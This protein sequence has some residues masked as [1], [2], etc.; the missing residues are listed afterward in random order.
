MGSKTRKSDTQAVQQ[1]KR[2]EIK[3]VINSLVGLAQSVDYHILDPEGLPP[4]TG[5][6]EFEKPVP[7]PKTVQF[8][9]YNRNLWI[10]VNTNKVLLKRIEFI[11]DQYYKVFVAFDVKSMDGSK[12][13]M[14]HKYSSIVEGIALLYHDNPRMELLSG[15]V[16]IEGDNLKEFLRFVDTA[17]NEVV[18][19]SEH[20]HMSPRD[21]FRRYHEVTGKG[22]SSIFAWSDLSAM[23][24]ITD[25]V[26]SYDEEYIGFEVRKKSDV[27]LILCNATQDPVDVI[28]IDYL[29]ESMYRIS[30]AT[31][32]RLPVAN[33]LVQ[34]VDEGSK[35]FA[36]YMELAKLV[37]LGVKAYAV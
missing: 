13:E 6:I 3:N 19:S 24:V 30:S 37:F 12:I 25:Y 17:L 22:N 4:I 15:R 31:L 16:K 34:L 18:Q 10:L 26:G 27:Y 32:A 9:V 23:Y 2:K 14:Y 11:D 1:D 21:L 28:G 20:V 36:N 7:I 5:T 29:K 33:T 8:A 35:L